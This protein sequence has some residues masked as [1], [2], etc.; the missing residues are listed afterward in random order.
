MIPREINQ[1]QE[2]GGWKETFYGVE[3]GLDCYF[4]I[5][6]I[7]QIQQETSRI[8]LKKQSSNVRHR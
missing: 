8:I 4:D 3:I 1:I 6:L 5:L 7:L 2:C